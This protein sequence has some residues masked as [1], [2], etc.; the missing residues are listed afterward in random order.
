MIHFLIMPFSFFFYKNPSL[1]VLAINNG[2]HLQIYNLSFQTTNLV[3]NTMAQNQ[4][5][6]AQIFKIFILIM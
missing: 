1:P 5:E 4:F 2:L 6:A 3:I